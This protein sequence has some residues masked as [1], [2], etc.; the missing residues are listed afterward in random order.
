VEAPAYTNY[1]IKLPNNKTLALSEVLSLEDINGKEESC[2]L[3]DSFV[4]GR[5]SY[6]GQLDRDLYVGFDRSSSTLNSNQHLTS[7]NTQA[8]IALNGGSSIV[9][10]L[11]YQR[12]LGAV[13]QILFLD[14][15]LSILET[16]F[17]WVKKDDVADQISDQADLAKM[18]AEVSENAAAINP[19]TWY[20]IMQQGTAE[21]KQAYYLLSTTKPNP[22]ETLTL[23][24]QVDNNLDAAIAAGKPADVIKSIQSQ[25]E[26]LYSS[27]SESGVATEL[28]KQ[29]KVDIF[30]ADWADPTKFGS[31]SR[32]VTGTFDE[33]LELALGAALEGKSDNIAK[34][35]DIGDSQ[36]SRLI[37]QQLELDKIS[38][39]RVNTLTLTTEKNKL[40]K[41]FQLVQSKAMNN[42]VL[43]FLW[44]GYGRFGLSVTKDFT[45][46]STDKRLADNYLQIMVNRNDVL[47]EFRDSTNWALGGVVLEQVASLLGSGV[48]REAFGMGPA[49]FIN[50]PYK[51]STYIGASE[52]STSIEFEAGKWR[53]ASSWDGESDATVFED[54]SDDPKYARMPLYISNMTLGANL[55]K[56]TFGADYYAVLAT[57]GPVL[58]WKLIKSPNEAFIPI[59][60]IL[61]LD[62]Y[63]ENFID[64]VHY[65]TSEVCQDSVVNNKITLY[66][67]ATAASQ[68]SNVAQIGMVNNLGT[69]S[70]NNLLRTLTGRGSGPWNQ[71]FRGAITAMS[72]IS[73]FDMV[74]QYAAGDGFRYTQT[75][76]DTGYSF[77]AYQE[78]DKKPKN[79]LASLTQKLSPLSS[80]KILGNMSFG[81]AL[82]GVGSTLS[83]DGM[84]EIINTR[85]IMQGQTG[86]VRPSELYYLHLDGATEVSLGVYSALENGGCFR[87]CED[88]GSVAICQTDS[89]TYLL[90]KA[91]GQKTQLSD[92][93]RALMSTLMQDIAKTVI[94]NV[95]ISSYMTCSADSNIFQAGTNARM[96]ALP[97]CSASECL[98]SELASLSGKSISGGDISTVMG[99]VSAVKT[100]NGI[101]FFEKGK[102]I[103]FIFTSGTKEQVKKLT[104]LAPGYLEIGGVAYNENDTK[105]TEA[106]KESGLLTET[107][108]KVGT[109]LTSPSEDAITT[110]ESSDTLSTSDAYGSALLN[111]KGNAKV[112]ISGYSSGTSY[113]EEDVGTLSA[114][115]FK[116]GRIEY[117]RANNRLVTALYILAEADAAAIS[118]ITV[119]PATNVNSNGTD[120][121]I[122]IDGLTAKPG[123]EAAVDAFNAALA[124]IQGTGGLQM[125]ETA[126]HI[127][128]FT[129][130]AAGKDVLK[131]CDK[132]TS[133]CKEYLITGTISSDG[134]TITVP[135]E[136]GTFQIG[137]GTNAN[138][139]YPQI[140]VSGP[141]G[142][143]EIATLLAAKGQNGMFSFDS[144]TGLFK[145]ING[146]SLNLNSDMASKGMSFIGTDNG[147]KGVASSNYL[148][149]GNQYGSSPYS[150][151]SPLSVPSV[152]VDNMPIAALMLVLVLSAVLAVRYCR[153]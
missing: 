50:S 23:L 66:A 96:I 103:R 64:P 68:I 114:I 19:N 30:S 18:K 118:G 136:K 44:L 132:N 97:G 29:L 152:P 1:K 134:T 3:D 125:L 127:Y 63:I 88:G 20:T 2:L 144:L 42:F 61:T 95:L 33:K 109:E 122:R 7:S 128:Y 11:R 36:S 40:D 111:I 14:T 107:V 151:S 12:F 28:N 94:P 82:K 86:M 150:T 123:N 10:P 17:M 65:S 148:G 116:N 6:A 52:S 4:Q 110:A 102:P 83:L 80:S 135:T 8:V 69:I 76:K 138:T 49:I 78:L 115:I 129:K 48:P 26:N 47:K 79:S 9:V 106:D 153:D 120:N 101:A 108:S 41:V 51:E 22:K 143:K 145:A 87:K 32:T 149:Y 25:R 71:Y 53:V 77:A 147:V 45:L 62:I 46:Q 21:Q 38:Q 43:G 98:T 104:V 84:T 112:S 105:V 91:T 13:K 99:E 54:V 57:L 16:G 92:R 67:A 34:A 27:L 15:S 142:F 139:G 85:M 100:S 74:K 90:D 137:F 131:I 60:R 72:Y 119:T 58:A 124:Q 39:K 75:C 146:Q 56:N 133:T 37:H 73:P 140:S 93:D 113:S 5:V 70:Q 24:T 55:N 121:A 117:D 89:G 81:D 130:N 59:A 141:D 35:F 31:A 126:D